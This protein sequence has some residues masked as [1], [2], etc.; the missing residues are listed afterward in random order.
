MLKAMRGSFHHLKWVLLAVIVA[1]IFGFVFIDMGMGGAGGASGAEVSYAARVNGES[2]SLRDYSRSLFY[3]EENYKGMYGQQL[4]P[5]MI[6]QMGLPRQVLDGL[7]DQRLMLQEA[8]RLNL[9]ATPEEVRKRIL[10]IPTLNPDGK[11]VGAELY[12]RYVTGSLGYQNTAEF[13]DELARDITVSKIESALA[14]SIVVSAKVAE[15]EYR[16][17]TETATIRYVLYPASRNAGS[18]AVTP[19]EVE[20]YYKANQAKYAHGEQ[21]NIK[22]LIADYARLRAAVLPNDE[23]L[24]RRYEAAKETYRSPEAARIF[25]ILIKV[26]PG[27]PAAADAAAKAKAD[28]LVAQ[29]RGGADFGPLAQANSGDPSSASN[30]GDMGFVDRGTTVEPFDTAAFTIPLNQISDPIRSQ[31]YGYHIIK[32]VERRQGGYK[33]FEEVKPQLSAQTADQVSK[34]QAR[35]E[36][37][38]IAN[39]IRDK[40]PA[41]PEEFTALATERIPS[42][43]SQWFQKTEQVP[44]L[45]FNPQLSEWVFSAKPGDVGERIGTSRGIIIP[46]LVAVRPAGVSPLAEIRARVEADA[47]SAKA[48]QAARDALASAMQGAPS[49]DVIGTKLG[50]TAADTTVSRAGVIQGFQGDTSQLVNSAMAAPVGSINGP[51]IA[52]DGAVVFQ[53]TEHKAVT[54]ED[55]QKNAA[56]YADTLRSQQARSL[57]T[58]LLQRLRKAAEVDINQAVLETNANRNI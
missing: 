57:R 23:E 19:A 53:V 15:A 35:D 45:G 32:V 20:A 50:L 26:D 43:D 56:Q 22:Y 10:Q 11:F 17:N 8:R 46:Y 51:V 14:S 58:V 1:F 34:D 37:A 7:I 2:I 31:E 29:L 49:V 21:R 48:S 47:K 41:T 25:H 3:T 39:R 16:R 33:S 40:K 54:P 4:T 28:A 27:S 5:E 13:E 6:E 38:R 18:I 52:G 36:M 42:N 55:L 9:G 24:R 44:G 12:S 30:G